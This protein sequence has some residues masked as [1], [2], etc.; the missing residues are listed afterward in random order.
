MTTF[1]VS[2]IILIRY[3]FVNHYAMPIPFWDEWDSEGDLLLRP[4]VDGTLKISDLWKL[5]NEHRIFPTRLLSLASYIVNGQWNNLV[6]ARINIILAATIPASLLGFLI[7]F[8]GLNSYKWIILPV[9]I[10]QFTLPFSFENMLVGFQSQFYFLILFTVIAVGLAVTYPQK[11]VANVFVLVLCLLSILTMASGILTPMAVAGVYLLH[12]LDKQ[13]K[14]LQHFLFIA[15]LVI[16]AGT[17]YMQIPHIA[18]HHIYRARSISEWT[19][20]FLRILSWPVGPHNWIAA[21]LWSPGLIAVSFLLRNKKLSKSDLFMAGC[22]MW[23]FAQAIAIAYGR[24]QELSSVPSRYTELLSIGLVA[25][26]WFAIR[27]MEEYKKRK[28]QKY[29]ILAIFPLFLH[30]HKKR[31]K[32]D[33][34]DIHRVYRHSVIQTDNVTKYLKTHNPVYLQQPAMHIPYPDSIRL[35]QLLD[36]PT[37]RRLLPPEISGSK[38]I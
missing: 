4:W 5:H 14:A 10:A 6:S 26:A 2:L 3:H 29:F 8:N 19:H 25:N 28:W 13:E 24:G 17:A 27:F 30:G 11:A 35:K 1:S 7:R 18:A 9:L 36:N 23:S 22:Y 33:M 15:T 32:F 31:F 21:P 12:W 16:V 37:I 38:H 20:S 34:E